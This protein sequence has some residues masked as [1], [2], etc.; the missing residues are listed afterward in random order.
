MVFDAF[1]RSA[2]AT[3]C[4]HLPISSSTIFSSSAVL[5]QMFAGTSNLKILPYSVF[6]KNPVNS[7]VKHLYIVFLCI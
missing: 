6:Y 3:H 1:L 4:H 7:G 5:N 2:F